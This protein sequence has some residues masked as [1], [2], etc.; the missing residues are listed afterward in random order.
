MDALNQS[1]GKEEIVAVL[2]SRGA[3]VSD[4]ELENLAKET[5]AADD[6]VDTLGLSGRLPRLLLLFS[7][8]MAR[9]PSL[10]SK[11]TFAMS[12]LMSK[13]LKSSDHLSSYLL[14]S[15]TFNVF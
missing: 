9:T 13:I 12:L 7:I 5:K 8:S 1:K 2:I 3:I 10:S 4:A 15:R 14:I 6:E 11:V